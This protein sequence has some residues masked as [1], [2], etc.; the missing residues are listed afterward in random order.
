MDEKIEREYNPIWRRRPPVT[1]TAGPVVATTTLVQH[2]R[3]T[4]APVVVEANYDYLAWGLVGA[5]VFLGGCFICL[6]CQRRRRHKIVVN[7]YNV[8]NNHNNNDSV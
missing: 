8:D 6:W 3:S 2:N 4:A 5:V 1:T 7:V